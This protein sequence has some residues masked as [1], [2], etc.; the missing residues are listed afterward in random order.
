MKSHESLRERC[1]EL[2]KFD[3]VN[4]FVYWK[5][6]FG[7]RKMGR[8]GWVSN[9]GYINMKVDGKLYRQ[10]RILFLVAHG[11]LPNQVDHKDGVR[12]NNVISNL[13][14]AT[15]SENQCNSRRYRSNSSGFKGV[16]REPRTGKWQA[17]IQKDKVCYHL[18]YFDSKED[19]RDVY[20]AAA[21]ELHGEFFKGVA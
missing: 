19:A 1:L 13:R 4:G 8:V 5:K 10:H 21:K 2:F 12:S 7:T 17:Q 11:Y 6:K 3:L 20:L 15:H 14:E 9:G 16:S 18:G